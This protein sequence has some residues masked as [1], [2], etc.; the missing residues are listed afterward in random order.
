MPIEMDR[1]STTAKNGSLHNA[2]KMPKKKHQQRLLQTDCHIG[3][4][5]SGL[6]GISC[7][8]AILRS[9]SQNN[10]PFKGRITIYERDAHL[11]DRKEGYGM[12]FTLTCIFGYIVL[13]VV[14]NS[15]H[16]LSANT[17]G[18]TLT[19]DPK[20]PLA[21][22]GVL[23]EVAKRDC[24]SRS[25]FIF[26]EKGEVKGYFGNSFY[27][28]AND[29]EENETAASRGTGQRGNLRIPRAELRSI[30]L[31]A[32]MEEAKKIETTNA[33]TSSDVSDGISRRVEISWNKRLL[34]YE[35][36]PM[37]EKLNQIHNSSNG[38]KKKGS[39]QNQNSNNQLLLSNDDRDLQRPVL[40]H[41][42]DGSTDQVDLLI[43]ADGVNSMVA[44]Q[45]LSTTIKKSA[46]SNKEESQ[47]V[48]EASANTNQLDT[49]PR[50]LGIFIMLGIS[51]HFH[52]L[53]DE[54]GF[55]TLDGRHRLFIMPFQGSRLD[56]QTTEQTETTDQNQSTRRHVRR[57]MWQLS[58]PISNQEE[59]SRLSKL[60]HEEMQAEVL[61][62]CGQW[63]E[64][65]PDMVRNTPLETIWGTSLL[66]R[67]PDVF[68]QHRAAL[69]KHCR[70]PSRV[71]LFGDAAHSMTPFKGQG[72]NQAL[73]DG[74]LLAKW[75]SRS[76]FDSAVRGFMRE[77]AQRSGIK[78]RASR[79]S[80]MNLHSDKC[81]EWMV[82]QDK[83][84]KETDATTTLAVF[85]GV[86]PQHVS[87]LLDILKERGVGANLGSKLDDTIRGII[88]E[89][90]IADTITSSDNSIYNQLSS[91]DMS[92]LQ[93]RALEYAS[94]GNMSQL[95]ELTR[96]SFL[97]VPNALDANQCSCL[98]LAAK[99]GHADVCRWLLSEVNISSNASDVNGKNPLDLAADSGH[100]ETARLLKRWMHQKEQPAN[101]D[102]ASAKEIDDQTDSSNVSPA[103]DSGN[104]D[105]YKH[106]EQ[107][108]RG[109][110]TV[111]QLSTLLQKNRNKSGSSE[112]A[113]THVLGCHLDANDK[114]YVREHT[115]RLADDHG[116]VLLRDFV[117][118]EADQLALGALALRPL[119]LDLS[120]ALESLSTGTNSDTFDA[121]TTIGIK[122]SI[123]KSERKGTNKCI[124]EIKSQL[125]MSAESNLVIVQ[126]NFGPQM[127][128]Y[129]ARE[130]NAK[131]KRKI[132]S[133]A[134]S[135][136]RY[137]NL[138]EWNYNWGDR[139]Y[140][141][142]PNAMVLPD[143]LVSL[144]EKAH[145]IAEKKTKNK[146]ATDPNFDMAICNLYHLHRPSDR[147]G[148]HQDN[149]ESNLSLPLVSI[150]LGSPGIFLI[151]GTSREVAPTA[152]LLRAGDCMVMSGKS[153]RYFHGVP[154]V[155]S[156]EL[157]DD[158]HD[159]DPILEE[160]LTIFPELSDDGSLVDNNGEDTD[161][162]I[163]GSLDVV[164][165]SEE[166]RF[167]K[168]LLTTVRMNMSLRQ[169]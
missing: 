30:L 92:D 53:I 64:P 19:Y 113:V 7:A 97:V 32:L 99:H 56:D 109:I 145:A 68:L 71:V 86:Q 91:Q 124:E 162:M 82:K 75:L 60:S 153:R 58:F 33:T 73:A 122:D 8:L 51:D 9:C 148:G 28:A 95:R 38:K 83:P 63:H 25:H 146:D 114:E 96:R 164:P 111:K 169:V 48:D 133:F 69:E 163:D 102:H 10:T 81:W 155:L 27:V 126:T 21:R 4:I 31:D 159:A 89:L 26:N 129:S 117:P 119:Q 94:T 42:E 121:L 6:G 101:C 108:L 77:M 22:L 132:D 65:F 152:I 62:R 123:A 112:D 85:H 49:A 167:V 76:K 157:G 2:K 156:N 130:N 147:L 150:S 24:P 14:I 5:G 87:K 52:S 166:M 18:M 39:V 50:Y 138:G 134:L 90:D 154:C 151:G 34:C 29:G 12:T 141:K 54:R 17:T 106:V 11:H 110:R 80:A 47:S 107:Q 100:E 46:R 16:F 115:K 158:A 61:K 103:P 149:V 116:A 70:L 98:H 57:T 160:S 161:A 84:M 143:R 59:A 120:S 88:L 1:E 40:L 78:V 135:R 44:R 144:A 41:F 45:Y 66:D 37:I 136:L 127:Q 3:I 104:N 125:T 23:E 67:D 142:V 128:S 15:M 79:E 35:D 43:G 131:K 137:V 93:K 140:E 74:P 72:A 20:G 105:A 55:Y 13:L 165:S 36:R 118:R 168:A 139:R